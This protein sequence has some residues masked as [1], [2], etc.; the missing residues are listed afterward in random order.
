M[1]TPLHIL[2]LYSMLSFVCHE[3]AVSCV[4]G[5]SL[6]AHLR[7]LFVITT[8]KPFL[9]EKPTIVI[10]LILL[11]GDASVELCLK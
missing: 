9:L 4:Q 7:S 5:E 6:R 1:V 3:L 8:K 10:S 2:C 11:I